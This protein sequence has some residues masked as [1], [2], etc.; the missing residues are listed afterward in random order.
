MEAITDPAQVTPE[1]LTGVLRAGSYLPQGYVARVEVTGSQIHT[2]TVWSLDVGYS[3]DALAH[4][5][6]R[7]YLKLGRRR[8]EVDFYNVVAPA[9]PDPPIARCYNAVYDAVKRA[10]PSA[11]RGSV[12]HAWRAG[13]RAAA[14]AALLR[15]AG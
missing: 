10:H 6:S 3:A 4:P 8:S 7:L 12:R 14:A 11:V 9:M 1:W 15:A 5:P 13:G 2:A